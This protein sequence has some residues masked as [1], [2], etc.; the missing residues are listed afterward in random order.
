M[1][2][3]IFIRIL[4]CANLSKIP[5]QIHN[6]V[7]LNLFPWDMDTELALTQNVVLGQ[8]KKFL[9]TSD[10]RTFCKLADIQTE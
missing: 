4:K 9:I 2:R 5:Y 1:F 6:Y 3:I 8:L 10:E 7:Y